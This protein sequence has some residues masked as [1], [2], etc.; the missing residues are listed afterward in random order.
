MLQ[1]KVCIPENF[2]LILRECNFES[3]RHSRKAS[4]S[5]QRRVGREIRNL[6]RATLPNEFRLVSFLASSSYP[7]TSIPYSG[8]GYKSGMSELKR[9]RFQR[10]CA[11]QT[12]SRTAA[13]NAK[14]ALPN[15]L[16]R[17]CVPQLLHF[18]CRRCL[19]LFE[20]RR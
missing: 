18:F 13:M 19:R 1:R 7:T 8:R 6:T 12:P 3:E 17:R 10:A 5:Q 9:C 2:S 16:W 14:V 11:T 4:V 15:S 20:I